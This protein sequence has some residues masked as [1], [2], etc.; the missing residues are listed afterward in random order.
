M[1][2]REDV[3]DRRGKGGRVNVWEARLKRNEFLACLEGAIFV[4]SV[5]SRGKKRLEIFANIQ[6]SRAQ[7]TPIASYARKPRKQLIQIDS[8]VPIIWTEFDFKQDRVD[9]CKQEFSFR[10]KTQPV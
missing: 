8:S 7:M 5:K 3:R 10:S 4:A 1:A 2:G 9:F 6:Q